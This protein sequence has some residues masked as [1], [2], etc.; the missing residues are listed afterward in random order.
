VNPIPLD[1]QTDVNPRYIY[2]F[3]QSKFIPPPGKT[4]LFMGQTSERINEYME[5]FPNKPVPGGWSAYWAVTEFVG[6][7]EAH[8][9]IT[10]STQDHQMLIDR[11][12]NTALHSAMWMVGMWN[13]ARNTINGK[14]DDVIKKYAI[15]VKNKAIPVYLRL[16]YEFDGP[17][18]ELD[19]EEYIKAY[20]HIVDLMRAEGVD[21]V[22]FI[23]HSYASKP[24]KDYPLEAWYPG[25]DYVD[26]V[27]ISVFYQPYYGVDLNPEG[28]AVLD[29]A[30]EHKKPVIIAESNPIFGIL[31][32][33]EEDWIKW[34]S[35]FFTMTYDKNIKAISFINEDWTKIAIEGLDQWNDARVYNISR[36][37]EAWFEETN[38]TRYLKQSND[39]FKQL[40]YQKNK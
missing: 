5:K 22:A 16:G 35:N 33:N 9:N 2:E 32:E 13:V 30:K 36:L 11:F 3:A 4:L 12:S 7:T 23:W 8:T 29:F 10:G 1:I 28:N 27:G 15:W 18:N 34:F 37:S 14:Y 40:G 17:H 20:R 39:L 31:K 38:K 21:N 25:D 26:W 19:P 6:V 24:Y